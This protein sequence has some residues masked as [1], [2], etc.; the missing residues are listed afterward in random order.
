M[1]AFNVQSTSTESPRSTSSTYSLC[2]W[3]ITC[4]AGLNFTKNI[5][6]TQ[7]VDL[8]IW[9]AHMGLA[10]YFL[11]VSFST[12]ILEPL[13]ASITLFLELGAMMLTAKILLIKFLKS[14]KKGPTENLN[15][16][17]HSQDNLDENNENAE[18]ADLESNVSAVGVNNE[19]AEMAD[20]ENN[21]N[22][23]VV[24]IIL[25]V[26][27]DQIQPLI[28]EDNGSPEIMENF[29]V[30]DEDSGGSGIENMENYEADS[31]DNGGRERRNIEVSDI[32]SE[33][34]QQ[35]QVVEE[36]DSLNVEETN[37]EDFENQIEGEDSETDETKCE[38]S[39]TE[40]NESDS[41]VILVSPLSHA[42]L[43]EGHDIAFEEYVFSANASFRDLKLIVNDRCDL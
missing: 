37:G 8:P 12:K 6:S 25:V 15:P 43:Q 42:A 3:I 29:E 35:S 33:E 36:N 27:E 40:I 1:E 39:S 23:Q 19:N 7:N 38:D 17:D 9:I 18:M 34:Q 20:L 16:D 14:Q 5:K 26:S 32:D 10:S 28:V 4:M 41:T 30:D 22:A 31:E 2:G 13:N 24:V 21:D 11:L